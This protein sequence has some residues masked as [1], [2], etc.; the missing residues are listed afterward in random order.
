M[1]NLKV[2]ENIWEKSNSLSKLNLSPL[3]LK[4]GYATAAVD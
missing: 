1:L 3:I 2:F 4:A